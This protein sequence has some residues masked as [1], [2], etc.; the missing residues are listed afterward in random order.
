M[1]S[2]QAC[3]HAL[4]RLMQ[5]IPWA[6]LGGFGIPYLGETDRLVVVV[7]A[8]T[9]AGHSEISGLQPNLLTLVVS[10]YAILG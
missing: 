10:W 5:L 9:C 2:V 3:M 4:I 7:V 1:Y 6:H 8:D